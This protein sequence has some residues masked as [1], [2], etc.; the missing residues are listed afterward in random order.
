[1]GR[2]LRPDRARC[3]LRPVLDAHAREEGRWRL[4]RCSGSKTWITNAPIADVAV[5]WAK[6]DD[7]MLRGFILERGMKGLTFPKIEGKF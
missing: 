6:D 3:R 4:H 5:V 2:L 7:G 1:M